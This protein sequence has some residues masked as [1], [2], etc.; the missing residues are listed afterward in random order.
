MRA[1]TMPSA[2]K[3]SAYFA[4]PVTFAT[5]S[6]GV[7]STPRCLYAMVDLRG[8]AC[9]AHDGIQIIV[10]SRAPAQVAGHRMARFFARGIRVALQQRH[11]SDHLARGAEAALRA[12]LV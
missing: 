6:C 2:R 4:S 7:K 3:S 12:E 1:N 10:V 9:G 8:V 11:R 5:T